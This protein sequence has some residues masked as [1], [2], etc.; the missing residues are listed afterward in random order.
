MGTV[1]RASAREVNMEKRPKNCPSARA[2]V[3]DQCASVAVIGGILTVVIL[4]IAAVAMLSSI[5]SVILG[6]TGETV[7]L[8]GIACIGLGVAGRTVLN[9]R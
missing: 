2:L 9:I 3:A 5:I 4:G 1:L 7:M 8:A 6:L